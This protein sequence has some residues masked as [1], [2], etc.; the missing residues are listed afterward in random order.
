MR[1]PI[2]HTNFINDMH[3]NGERCFI[4]DYDRQSHMYWIRFD[5]GGTLWAYS[6][7][8]IDEQEGYYYGKDLNFRKRKE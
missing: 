1:R 8:L 6:Y 2:F 3:R 7:E 4:E 5:D